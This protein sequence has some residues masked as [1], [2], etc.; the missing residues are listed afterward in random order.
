M[1]I[2]RNIFIMYAIALL[3]GMVF[4]APVA[5]LYRSAA[6]VDIFGITVIE[7]ISLALCVLL[8]LPWG[9]LAD[10]IGYRNTMIICCVLYFLSKIVFFKASGFWGFL[11]ERVMLSVVMSGLSGVDTSVLYLSC[12]KEKAQNVFGIY[13]N[14]AAAGLLFAAAVYSLFV[15]SNYRLAGFL[16][17]ISYALAA[18]LVFFLTD[19]RPSEKHKSDDFCEFKNILHDVIKAKYIFP[20]VVAIALLNETHQT[21]TTFLNQLQFVKCGMSDKA[22]GA[23]YIIVTV[24]G[25]IGGFSAKITN[26][27]GRKNFGVLLYSVVI[28]ACLILAFTVNALFSIAAIIILRAAFC[29][30]APLQ[31]DIQ[32]RLIKSRNRATALSVNAV[33]MEGAAVLTNL[34]FGAAAKINLTYAMLFGAAFS[35]VGLIIYTVVFKSPLFKEE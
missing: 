21:V 27:L 2:K 11:L 34:V 4:Y 28:A 3:Q 13:N 26:I 35:L 32:N 6:G 1:Y 33:I 18:V 7:S 29:L 17:V 14:L 12:E 8:E 5:T 23:V 9:I 15:G 16:T 31:T 10:K 24:T 20:L 22:I 30:F 25:L 19:V